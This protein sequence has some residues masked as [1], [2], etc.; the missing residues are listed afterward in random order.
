M[1]SLEEILT[2]AQAKFN[3]QNEEIILIINKGDFISIEE[4][5][6]NPSIT[7]FVNNHI[8]RIHESKGAIV[9]NE[10]YWVYLLQP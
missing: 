3:E 1:L 2:E 8:T 9:W 6:F 4:D 5:K 10:N 7:R